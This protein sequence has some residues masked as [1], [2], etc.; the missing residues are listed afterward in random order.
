MGI[1]NI[2]GKKSDFHLANGNESIL[3]FFQNNSSQIMDSWNNIINMLSGHSERLFSF[4]ERIDKV[5]KSLDVFDD[6]LNSSNGGFEKISETINNSSVINSRESIDKTANAFMQ[7]PLMIPN[8][9]FSHNNSVSSI[10]RDSFIFG[11]NSSSI[12]NSLFERDFAKEGA[13][14]LE[15]LIER[16]YGAQDESSSVNNFTSM[17]MMNSSSIF[18][19]NNSISSMFR[20]ISALRESSS[21]MGGLAESSRYFQ[22]IGDFY[23][24][25]SNSSSKE[26]LLKI[27][28]GGGDSGG[29]SSISSSE[30]SNSVRE[31]I[32][33]QLVRELK[34]EDKTFNS[35]S[36]SSSGSSGNTLID[37]IFVNIN[38]IKTI[39]DLEDFVD[40]L[41]E[42]IKRTN[43]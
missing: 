22:D 29:L 34:Q 9:I 8:S 42:A 33:S 35:S 13:G 23:S 5:N 11:N 36:N 39:K 27:L 15:S 41:G 14:S 31:S 10:F 40:I 25:F 38:D 3:S 20:D 17:S 37:K 16:H 7:M 12:R 32:I 4:G 30:Y 21:F 28:T 19:S 43:G 6:K 1:K 26:G 24:S 18:S 2:N